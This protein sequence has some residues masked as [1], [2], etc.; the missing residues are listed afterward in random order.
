ME[1]YKKSCEDELDWVVVN[2][3][4]EATLQMS[5]SCFEFKKICVGLIGAVLAVIS[6]LTNGEVNHSYFYILLIL[7]FGFWI[8][9]SSAYYFQRKTRS[10]ME[11]KLAALAKRNS[12][13]SYSSDKL[14]VS[15]FKAAFNYSM[16]LYHIFIA[17]DIIG[18][19]IFVH[20]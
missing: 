6:K 10:I 8:A 1:E 2:Q 3:L 5:K 11:G 15:W 4:H 20:R 9:D 16:V 13:Q 17:I 18:W 7:C 12:I 14:E 19:I